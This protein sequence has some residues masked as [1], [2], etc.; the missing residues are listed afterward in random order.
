MGHAR[1]LLGSSDPDRVCARVIKE[2]LSVRETERLAKNFDGAGDG[3]A[4]KSKNRAKTTASLVRKDADTRALER[5]LAAI[6]GLEVNIDHKSK[7]A[8]AV[9]LKYMTLDQLDDICRRLM[10][11][12]V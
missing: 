2:N 12:R 3:S 5:D 1:A 10:G 4:K 6:L 11:A 7:G 8:G 9:T